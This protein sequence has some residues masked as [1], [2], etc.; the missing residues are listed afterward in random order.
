[1]ES[2]ASSPF[3]IAALAGV[4]SGVGWGIPENAFAA[5]ARDLRGA[6]GRAAADLARRRSGNPA[7]RSGSRP[8][9]ASGI[10]NASKPGTRAATLFGHAD[11][12]SVWARRLAHGGV[13]TAVALGAWE[14]SQGKSPST[15]AVETVTG[16]VV[17]I[18]ATAA[19]GAVIVAAGI[20]APVW[21]PV[22]VGVAAGAAAT[23]AAGWAYEEFVP[24]DVREKIDEG[25]KDTW[26]GAKDVA[27]DVGDAI[28]D[29]WK[30]VF[31]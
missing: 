12:A 25:I 4:L 31:G 6:A 5:K 13:V 26:E 24:Q 18:A 3:S 15:V 19:V 17:G 20:S 1:M 14:I 16:V 11:E 10:A 30:S 29:G 27:G 28:S 21:V 22:A 9:R 8:P 23:A 2:E 7:V